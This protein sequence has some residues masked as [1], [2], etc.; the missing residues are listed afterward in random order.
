MKLKSRAGFSCY[1]TDLGKTIQFYEA[2]GVEF[3]VKKDDHAVAYINWYRMD[4]ISVSKADRPEFVDQSELQNKGLGV[5]LN[6]SVDNV[7][8][9]YQELVEKGL[10]PS[11]PRKFLDNYEFVVTDPDGYKIVIFKRK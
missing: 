1:V 11:E 4:F 5:F 10:K 2:L 8:E 9:S 7:D 3:K 6:F